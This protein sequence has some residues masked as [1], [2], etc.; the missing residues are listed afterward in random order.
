MQSVHFGRI[1]QLLIR[2][3]EPVLTPRPHIYCER[4][5]GGENGPHP[6][7]AAANFLLKQQV[8]ELF[9]FFDQQQNGTIDVLEIKHGLP[10]R[11][12]VAEVPA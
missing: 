3:G 2:N 1:E 4:K 9:A 10:F 6:E 5:F 11:M 7:V 12:I 8:M